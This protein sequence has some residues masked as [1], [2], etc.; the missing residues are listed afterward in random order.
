MMDSNREVGGAEKALERWL[1]KQAT[2]GVPELVLM[3]FLREVA[4][5]IEECRYIS[6]EER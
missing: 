3:S 4:D 1:V 6:R 2:E 5:D